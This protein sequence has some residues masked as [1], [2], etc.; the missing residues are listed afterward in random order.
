MELRQEKYVFDYKEPF[1]A[2]TMVR[3]VTK[4]FKLSRAYQTQ[5]VLVMVVSCLFLGLFFWKIAFGINRFTI[6]LTFLGS[7][8]LMTLLNRYEPEGKTPFKFLSDYAV[9]VYE[10][11][12]PRNCFYHDEKVKIQTEK[13]VY[14][15]EQKKDILIGESS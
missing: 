10:W 8:G 1:R 15:Q 7:Y 9:Y 11:Q 4:K 13:C 3:E 6:M 14:E 2:P 12:L 5:D